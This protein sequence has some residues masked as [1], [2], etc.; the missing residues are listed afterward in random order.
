MPIEKHIRQP[1]DLVAVLVGVAVVD[2]RHLHPRRLGGLHADQSALRGS[3]PTLAGIGQTPSE[4]MIV[5]SMSKMT[6]FFPTC[7]LSTNE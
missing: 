2:H 5:P 4:S 7:N 6:A 1:L 3:V